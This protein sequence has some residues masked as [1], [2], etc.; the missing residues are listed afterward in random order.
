M[1]LLPII[2]HGLAKDA[3]KPTCATMF[4]LF[5][6]L[7]PRFR[8]P[9]RGSQ[10][11]LELRK[12]LGLDTHEE[13]AKFAASWF[14]RLML[15]TVVR[16]TAV[17]VTC[18][19]LS[20]T[21]YQFLTLNG[22][23]E[24]WNPRSDEGLNLTQTKI[25]VLAFLSSGA[26]NDEERFL[27]ALFASGDSNSRISSVG[28]DLLKRSTLSLEEPEMINRL[29]D[30]YFTLKPALQTRLLVLL[31]KSAVSTTFPDKVVRIVQEALQPDDNT[32]LPAKVRVSF[33]HCISRDLEAGNFKA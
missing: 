8:I 7:L 17:G 24:A 30:I 23:I 31:T 26:F 25:S 12:Q 20:V 27:A 10:E 9:L 3:E 6:R 5:L 33:F 18:P 1:D 16:S 2:L 4:N 28:D 13:D 15:L 29:L 21:E 14:A 11:D 32:N 19:G 22:K